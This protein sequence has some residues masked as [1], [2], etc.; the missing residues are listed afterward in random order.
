MTATSS[1]MA[2]TSFSMLGWRSSNKQLHKRSLFS[3]SAQQAEV[4]QSEREEENKKLKQ[5]G[6]I[7]MPPRSVEP[8]LN[9]Q[10]KN[11]GREY[12]GPWLSSRSR[13]ELVDHYEGAPLTEYTLRLIGSDIEHYIRKFLYEGEIQYNMDARVLNFSMGKPRV[14]FSYNGQLQDVK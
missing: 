4:K 1:I 3:V 12:G 2:P 10:S 13:Y 6:P 7:M 8:Q 9:V 14:R 5:E 11:M